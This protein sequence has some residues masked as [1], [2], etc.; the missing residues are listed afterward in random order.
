LWHYADTRPRL[1]PT[2]GH[3][4][5]QQANRTAV[6]RSQAEAATQRSRLAGAIGA[7]QAEAFAAFKAERKRVNGWL[8]VVGLGKPIDDQRG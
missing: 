6:G 3:R 1:T 2:C 5:A 7:K 8:A 4:F